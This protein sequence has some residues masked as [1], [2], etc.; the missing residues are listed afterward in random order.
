M[1][2]GQRKLDLSLFMELNKVLHN[3][4]TTKKVYCIIM[5][6]IILGIIKVG[7]NFMIP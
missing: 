1:L 5:K 2:I 6:S 3:L 4:I 7:I